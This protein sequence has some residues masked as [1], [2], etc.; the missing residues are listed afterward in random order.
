M[1]Q[2]RALLI[3]GC[4]TLAMLAVT[5]PLTALASPMRDGAAFTVHIPDGDCDTTVSSDSSVDCTDIANPDRFLLTVPSGSGITNWNK[6]NWQYELALGDQVDTFDATFTADV[7]ASISMGVCANTGLSDCTVAYSHSYGT[8]QTATVVHVDFTDDERRFL[9]LGLSVDGA[10]GYARFDDVEFAGNLGY[11]RP[12]R[13][14]Q[15]LSEIA[16]ATLFDLQVD[17][18]ATVYAATD[19]VIANVRYEPTGWAFSLLNGSTGERYEYSQLGAV[20]VVQGDTVVAGCKAGLA[21]SFYSSYLGT[22]T[23]QLTFETVVNYGGDWHTWAEPSI[24][25]TNCNTQNDTTHCL[26]SNPNLNSGLSEWAVNSSTEPF[27][28]TTDNGIDLLSAGPDGDGSIWINVPLPSPGTLYVTVGGQ[29][30]GLTATSLT[31]TVGDVS[32][33]INLGANGTIG[34]YDVITTVGLSPAT[35]NYDPDIYELR[36]SNTTIAQPGRIAPIARVSYICLHAG[37]A[38][39]APQRCF[40]GDSF[41]SFAET[42]DWETTGGATYQPG[43]FLSLP[44]YNLPNDDK[45]K[46]AITISAFTD[47]DT[48]Y[49][50]DLHWKPHVT[51]ADVESEITVTIR[52]SDTDDLLQSVGV[53]TSNAV[54]DPVVGAVDTATFTLTEA[55][56]L[57]GKLVIHNTSSGSD[58]TSVD[59]MGVCLSPVDSDGNE[60]GVWPGYDN[61]DSAFGLT[62]DC[63]VCQFPTDPT[64]IGQWLF[65]M[66]CLINFLIRCLLLAP[67]NA[68]LG[69]VDSIVTGIGLLG[70]WLSAVI[71]TFAIWA[72]T[73]ALRMLGN[74]LAFLMPIVNAVLAW[75]FSQTW[76]LSVLD[77]ATIALEWL[78]ALWAMFVSVLYLIAFVFNLIG[79]FVAFIGQAITI[80]YDGFTAGAGSPVLIPDCSDT[81]D[82]LY[83]M[84]LGFDILNF[85]ITQIPALIGLVAVIGFRVI[86]RQ[87]SLGVKQ[88]EEVASRL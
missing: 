83:H 66:G 79:S 1:K 42:D 21:S 74:V 14:E 18:D 40:F 41:R 87:I 81:G 32:S 48:N 15:V 27:S 56:S 22:P 29:S 28:T 54:T 4:L 77:A 5:S 30:M 84:C 71:A 24:T 8:A 70:R 10:P 46:H 52:D 80:I 16:G 12:V 17:A 38:V 19:G 11:I 9:F 6:G 25:A 60:T 62:E 72:Y 59:I 39:I 26:N 53:L 50:L 85:I 65:W 76:F 45:I 61:S 88:I 43:A 58:V 2:L 78:E 64:N 13:T 31:I 73:T 57:D 68:I 86:W 44:S 47:A 67:I 69:W 20:Y 7:A 36:V 3:V 23:S 34:D 37:D 49:K 33:I 51:G 75:L 55:T 63:S 82:P 35:P